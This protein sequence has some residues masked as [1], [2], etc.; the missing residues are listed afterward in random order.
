M[1][2]RAMVMFLGVVLVLIG[3]AGCGGSTQG[4]GGITVEGRLLEVNGAPIGG[5]TVFE[6]ATGASTTTA[7]D[8]AFALEAPSGVPTI[9]LL[10][11]VGAASAQA[12]IPVPAGTRRVA[13][14]F[15]LDRDRQRVD[16]EEVEI[17]SG[18]D[19]Q[20]GG[21]DDDPIDDDSGPDD[22][23]GSDDGHDSGSGGGDDSGDDDGDDGSDDDGGD[24]DGSDDDGDGGGDDD[25]DGG[26]D[27][28]KDDGGR[29]EE[30]GELQSVSA[31]QVVVDGTVF[32][33]VPSTRYRGANGAPVT[34]GYFSVGMEV[35]ARGIVQGGELILERLE[36]EDDEDS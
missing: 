31:N 14:R 16:P 24:G 15:R 12:S 23:S 21:D 33:P 22:D 18:D 20:G 6:V 5:A 3:L 11:Q 25:G 19:D 34:L 17:G 35:K 32:R 30:R 2:R 13:A 26:D 1:N 36:E 4:T 9:E 8:G 29:I 27:S 28:Q 10:F 7:G